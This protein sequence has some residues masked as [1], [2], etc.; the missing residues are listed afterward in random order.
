MGTPIH[1]IRNNLAHCF[2]WIYSRVIT[3]LQYTLAVR[4]MLQSNKNIIVFLLGLLSQRAKNIFPVQPRFIDN[5]LGTT[6]LSKSNTPNNELPTSMTSRASFG[7]AGL[8]LP[9]RISQSLG[10]CVVFCFV[11]SFQGQICGM[12]KFPG[13]RSN[14]SCSCQPTPQP[15]QLRIQATSATYTT[16]HGNAGSLTH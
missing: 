2:S 12:W 10:G 1:I 5:H 16:A 13:Q 9:G 14:R 4:K 6:S 7:N 3:Q 8:M 11:L 15:Q